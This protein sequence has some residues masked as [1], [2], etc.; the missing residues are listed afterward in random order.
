MSAC[1]ANQYGV[2]TIRLM[3]IRW[4]ALRRL[5]NWKQKGICA[6]I[7][8]IDIRRIDIWQ[9]DIQRNDIRRKAR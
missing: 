6:T 1:N 9:I 4:T 2:L 3:S 8:R 7:Q 5:G